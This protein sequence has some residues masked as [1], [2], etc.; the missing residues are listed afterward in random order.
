MSAVVALSDVLRAG[1]AVPV[2]AG[3]HDTAVQVLRFCHELKFLNV[4]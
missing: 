4:R 2:P 1:Y 3:E